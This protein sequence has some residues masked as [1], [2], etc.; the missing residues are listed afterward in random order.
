MFQYTE[1]KQKSEQCSVMKI[2]A[3]ASDHII[4]FAHCIPFSLCVILLLHFAKACSQL[5][6]TLLYESFIHIKSV[7]SLNYPTSLHPKWNC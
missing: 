2:F 6:C 5:G 3:S 1:M 7:C 4:T